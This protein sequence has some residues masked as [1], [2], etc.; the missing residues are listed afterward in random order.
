MLSISNVASPASAFTIGDGT[1]T[2][3]YLPSYSYYGYSYT[4]QLF[5]ASEIGSPRSIESVTFD[6]ANYAVNRTYKIYLMNTTATSGVWP[7]TSS[8]HP[9]GEWRC[10]PCAR[11]PRH[12]RSGV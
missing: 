11:R 2:N 4:Q 1:A 12:R 8:R 5:L 10:L 6:M 3:S 7:P 9:A